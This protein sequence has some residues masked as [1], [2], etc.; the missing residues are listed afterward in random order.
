MRIAIPYNGVF[1][2][3]APL[4]E[5]LT[6]SALLSLCIAL[7]MAYRFSQT[8]TQPLREISEEVSKIKDN[9]LFEFNYYSYDEFNIIATKLKE[10]AEN[11]SK[12]D[13]IVKE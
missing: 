10:Q 7:A 8:L 11:D 5:P 13:G 12:Y 1:D 9:R 3:A 4:V 6:I 2:N